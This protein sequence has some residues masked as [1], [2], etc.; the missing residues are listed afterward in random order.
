MDYPHKPS[1]RLVVAILAL[2]SVGLIVWAVVSFISSRSSQPKV[3]TVVDSDEQEKA[4]ILRL[5]TAD[6]P[7]LTETE[8]TQVLKSLTLKSTNTNQKSTSSPPPKPVTA[9]ETERLAELLRIKN[10]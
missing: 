9:E 5:I 7:P 2:V 3:A 10:N 8:R 4:Q 1:G 6:L